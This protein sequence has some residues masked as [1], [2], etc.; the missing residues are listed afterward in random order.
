[1]KHF[2]QHLK[3]WD[4]F[5]KR[6]DDSVFFQETIKIYSKMDGGILRR[7]LEEYARAS[8]ERDVTNQLSRDVPHNFETYKEVKK[9]LTF[10]DKVEKN[11]WQSKQKPIR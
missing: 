4:L 1:M 9:L 7:F 11:F 3:F 6:E 5:T 2:F 10:L 8:T